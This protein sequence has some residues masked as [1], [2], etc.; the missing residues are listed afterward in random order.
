M[1]SS[2]RPYVVQCLDCGAHKTVQKGNHH[3]WC[4]CGSDRFDW[5]RPVSDPDAPEAAAQAEAW[6]EW[7]AR[8]MV[9]AD[10]VAHAA[11]KGAAAQDEVVGARNVLAAHLEAAPSIAAAGELQV[12]VHSTEF[13]AARGHWKMVVWAE[14]EVPVGTPLTARGVTRAAPAPREG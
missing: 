4:A 1:S 13:V 14:R 10:N 3:P 12:A 5:T 9:L 11:S 8:A 2:S 7:L 6:Q